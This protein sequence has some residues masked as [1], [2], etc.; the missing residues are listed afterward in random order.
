LIEFLY[1]GKAFVS[2]SNIII[3]FI[4]MKKYTSIPA[5]NFELKY[6]QIFSYVVKYYNTH[7]MDENFDIFVS[8]LKFQNAPLKYYYKLWSEQKYIRKNNYFLN[9]LILKEC[10]SRNISSKSEIIDIYSQKGFKL[11]NGTNLTKVSGND[12]LA[13]SSKRYSCWKIKILQSFTTETMG[14]GVSD[15]SRTKGSQFLT[16]KSEKNGLFLILSNG[17]EIS[18]D[19]NSQNYVPFQKGIFLI[20]LI[21]GDEIKFTVV[22]KLTMI[23]EYNNKKFEKFLGFSPHI[24]VLLK[25]NQTRIEVEILDE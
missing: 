13:F 3:F 12:N 25:K 11:F 2:K 19:S 9:E 18:P 8:L 15:K 7:E 17:Y 20:I 16:N 22:D 6:D 24:C 14:V 5:S 23:V 1:D 21:Q 4:M 10:E